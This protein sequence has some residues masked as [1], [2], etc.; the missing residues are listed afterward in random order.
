VLTEVF[1]DGEAPTRLCDRHQSWMQQQE[2]AES[3]HA[4]DAGDSGDEDGDR[5]AADDDV[6]RIGRRGGAEGA[7]NPHPAHPFRSWL[8]RIFGGDR[9][10]RDPGRD[11]GRN[12]GDQDR[13]PPR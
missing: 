8:H 2:I 3:M 13:K 7:P 9:P 11:S 12:P 1:R 10:G 5:G 4:G 6:I